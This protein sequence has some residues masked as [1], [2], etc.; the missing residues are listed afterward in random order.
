M[1]TAS[2][3]ADFETFTDLLSNILKAA[4]GENWGQFTEEDPIG[5][6][7]D[8]V[9]LP[10]ITYEVYSRTPSKD[11]RTH[12][13]K[14]WDSFSDPDYPDSNIMV[15]KQWFDYIVDFK[16][17]AKTKK[18]ARQLCEKLEDVLLIYAGLF[19]DAGVADIIFQMESAP[20]VINQSRQD[21]PCRVLRYLV[22]IER[23]H[24]VRT[25]ALEEVLARVD[26]AIHTTIRVKEEF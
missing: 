2:G 12:K 3:N 25:K 22:R 8:A 17:F 9:V 7:P 15:Y 24:M 1:L 26:N 6:T 5:N 11:V 13:P 10:V 14:K 23:T 20:E 19:K 4:W 21:I 18:E 16:V